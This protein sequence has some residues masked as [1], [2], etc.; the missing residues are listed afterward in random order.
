MEVTPVPPPW[1][2]SL[3][4][5]SNMILPIPPPRLSSLSKSSNMILP[6]HLS[7]SEEMLSKTGDS[8]CC[9]YVMDDLSEEM[10]SKTV[11]F[12]EGGSGNEFPCQAD[13]EILLLRILTSWLCICSELY[14]WDTWILASWL[15]SCSELYKLRQQLQRPE[16]L[17]CPHVCWCW[18]WSQQ[19]TCKWLRR[20][21]CLSITKMYLITCFSSEWPETCSFDDRHLPFF[22]HLQLN[23][24][25]RTTKAPSPSVQ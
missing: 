5:S 8:F 14:K 18:T 19:L 3:S 17:H 16:M 24:W 22:N 1:L 11:L 6:T 13:W 21:K 9:Y 4:K 7:L 23:D 20:G 15:F 25:G 10:L 2:S 12:V